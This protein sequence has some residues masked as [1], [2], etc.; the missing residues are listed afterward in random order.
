MK[1]AVSRLVV[2]VP[3]H[4]AI[5]PGVQGEILKVVILKAITN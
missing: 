1:F 3:K 4:Q 5:N 2:L